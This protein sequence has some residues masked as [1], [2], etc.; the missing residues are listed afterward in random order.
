MA[1]GVVGVGADLL[2]GHGGSSAARVFPVGLDSF[3]MRP[4]G[5]GF[6]GPADAGSV[7]VATQAT[8]MAE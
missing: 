1:F 6:R 3:S 2:L 7:R 8:D 5:V 4:S